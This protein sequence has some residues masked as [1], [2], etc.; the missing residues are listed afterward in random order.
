MSDQNKSGSCLCGQITFSFDADPIGMGQCHCRDCQK[1]AGG[2]P[3]HV[4]LVP[5]D[6]LSVNGETKSITVQAAS[7]NEVARV[8]CPNCGTH[9]WFDGGDALPFYPLK[10]GT[11]DDP[12]AYKPGAVLWTSSAQP[13]HIIPD[14]AAHFDRDI[15]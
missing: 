11:L 5:K 3:G 9:L 12:S 1:V 14:D 13:W 6:S 2:A 4:V 7:G 15:G 10:V 8:F